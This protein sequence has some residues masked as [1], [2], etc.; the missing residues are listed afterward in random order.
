[1]QS[2]LA[3]LYEHGLGGLPQDDGEAARLYR[4][5]ADRGI[6]QAQGNLAL[7]YEQ[8]RGGL[9]KDDHEAARLRKLALDQGYVPVSE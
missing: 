3:V 9:A 5:A 2:N 6:A 7:F 4:L 8:G 1:V